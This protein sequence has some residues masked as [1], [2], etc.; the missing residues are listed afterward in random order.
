MDPSVSAACLTP[1]TILHCSSHRLGY[2]FGLFSS[3]IS[4]SLTPYIAVCIAPSLCLAVA[5]LSLHSSNL[6]W[7]CSWNMLLVLVWLALLFSS[8]SGLCPSV[9]F[10]P[11][12]VVES[13]A[14]PAWIFL[15]PSPFLLYISRYSC[16]TT[17]ART[18]TGLYIHP[19]EHCIPIPYSCSDGTLGTQ[20]APSGV[21]VGAFFSI[22]SH[23]HPYLPRGRRRVG[24]AGS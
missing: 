13:Y 14:H 2:F 20:H 8:S 18:C 6:A 23:P 21:G 3:F 12:S 5:H 22:S 24:G 10:R 16:C 15:L 7:I 4:S 19:H 1:H 11:L 9:A 17:T